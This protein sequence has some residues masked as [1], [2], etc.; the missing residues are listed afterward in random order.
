M[1]DASETLR[2]IILDLVP[3]D[4][5]TIGNKTLLA[6]IEEQLTEVSEDD[7]FAARD[8]LVDEGLVVKGRGR[9][10]SVRADR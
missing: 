2:K 8:A 7:Y 6:A 4:G 5:S 1:G 10:G 9:G 3:E